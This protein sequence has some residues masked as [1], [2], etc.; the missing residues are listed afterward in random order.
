MT[1]G[2]VLGTSGTQCTRSARGA[3]PLTL[4]IPIYPTAPKLEFNSPSLADH[5]TNMNNIYV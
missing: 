4:I 3:G 5:S 1:A 2:N